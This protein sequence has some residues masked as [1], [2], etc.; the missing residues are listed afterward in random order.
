MRAEADAVAA[1]G[2]RAY[3]IPLGGSNA[4]GGLGYVACVQE[5]LQQWFERGVAMD[6]VI[7]GSGS[8]GTHGGMLAGFIGHR[9][10][11]RLIGIDVS[12]DPEQ[13]VPLVRS[14]AR[15]V[16]DLLGVAADVPDDAVRCVGG[17]WRPS[18]SSR[19]RAWWRRSRSWRAPRACCSIPST[20]AR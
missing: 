2:R 20:P 7:V 16:L 17:Y 8:S 10:A 19:T 1:L 12:R 11:A 3:S 4:L 5:L 15:A 18:T 9:V 6:H 14:E 13:Q